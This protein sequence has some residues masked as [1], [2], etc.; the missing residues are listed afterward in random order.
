M[1]LKDLDK[2]TDSYIYFSR[3]KTSFIFFRIV[4]VLIISREMLVCTINFLYALDYSNSK[5]Y[6]VLNSINR[7]F[8]ENT[9]DTIEFLV[10]SWIYKSQ[11]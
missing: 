1:S 8:Y 5:F 4:V 9:V 11:N 7:T 2:S 3:I 10:L 6:Y